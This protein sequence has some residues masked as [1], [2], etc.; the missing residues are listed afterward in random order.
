MRTLRILAG[1][2][3]IT[4]VTAWGAGTAFASGLPNPNATAY[5]VTAASR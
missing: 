5:M 4:L 2:T 1:F 3:T